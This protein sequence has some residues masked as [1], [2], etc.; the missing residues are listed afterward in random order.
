MTLSFLAPVNALS[1]RQGESKTYELSVVDEVNQPVPLD[2]VRIIFSVKERL[3]ES[4]P[5]IQKSTDV[6]T[7]VI[8]TSVSGG[9]AR[10]FLV[11]EDTATL[12][13]GDYFFDVWVFFLATGRAHPVVIPSLFQIEPSVTRRLP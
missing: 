11:P 13:A 7:E 4:V 12:A 8:V 2:N 1:V 10:I 5:L 3:S 6:V 9:L